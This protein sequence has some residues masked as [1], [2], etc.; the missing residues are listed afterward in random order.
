MNIHEASRPKTVPVID[1]FVSVDTRSVNVENVFQVFEF[2]A[3]A[4]ESI[5]SDS[6]EMHSNRVGYSFH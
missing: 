5:E 6:M 1:R 4:R 3:D 2:D